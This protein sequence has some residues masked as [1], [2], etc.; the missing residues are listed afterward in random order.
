MLVLTPTDFTV[1]IPAVYPV[2]VPPAATAILTSTVL[3]FTA[4]VFPTPRKL[5]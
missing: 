1:A 5:I 3:P 4:K 2:H